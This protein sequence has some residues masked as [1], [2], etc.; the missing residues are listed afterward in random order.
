MQICPNC[1]EQNPDR[2]RLCGIC[3]TQFASEQVVEEVRKTVTVVFSD[4]KG[5]TDLGERLDTERLREVLNVYFNEMRSVLERHGGTVEKYIGDAIMAV[6]GLPKVHEDDAIRAVRAAFEMKRTLEQVNDR[7]EAGWGV[8][9]QNRTG[10]NTG[11][12]VAGDVSTGQRLV[13]GDTVNTAARLEQAAPAMEILIGEPTYRLVRDAVQVEPVEPLELKGK[14][15]PVPAYLLAGVLEKA[16]GIARRLDAPMVGRDKEFRTLVEALERAETERTA[17]LVT[18][19]GPAGVGKSRLLREFLHAT[20]GRANALRGRCLSYGDG[21]TFWP[22]A[23][24]IREAAGITDADPLDDARAKLGL[25]AGHEGHDAAERVAA[26]IGL[27][28]ATFPIQETFWG[29]R[30]LVEVLTR[31]RPTI[32]VIDDIHWA[33]DTFLELLQYLAGHVEAPLL[34]LCSSRPELLEDHADWI[35]ERDDARTILL[36]ALTE[37]ESE[38]VI[39]NLLGSAIGG[40]LRTAII[41]A[42]QGNPL[43]VE[44]MLSMLMEEGVV[45]QDGAGRWTLLGDVKAQTIPPSISALIT[46]RLDRLRSSERTVIERAAVIG[47]RFVRDAVEHLVATPVRPQVD[48]SLDALA[49]KEL[50]RRDGTDLVRHDAY[51]FLHIL[52]RDAAYHGLLKRTRAELHERFVDWLES[53]QSDR[54]TEYDEIRGYHLEQAYL[55][56]LQL[57][58][59]DEVT[60]RIGI[61]GAGYLSSS[62][63]RA[64]ARGDMPAAATLLR[65]AA[66]LLPPADVERAHLLLEAGEALIEV[67]EFATADD[68]LSAAQESGADI[69]D[70]AICE[71]AGLVRLQLRYSTQ[72]AEERAIVDEVQRAMAVLEREDAHDGLSRAWRLLTIVHWTA[73]RYAAAEDATLQMI[74]H[75]RV[76]GD[77]ITGRRYLG[78]LAISELYGPTPASEAIKRCEELLFEA[79]GDRKAEALISCALA[80]LEAMEGEFE[81]AR[82]LFARSRASFEELGWNLDA[83]L[84]SIDSGP[85]ELLAGDPRAAEAELRRDFDALKAMGEANYIS[86][87]AGL[88]ADAVY[89]QD[90]IDESEALTTF[91][92]EVAADDDV[93]SQVLWRCVRAKILARRGRFDDGV[94]L[95]KEAVAMI[96]ASDCLD[97]QGI[98]AMDLADVLRSAGRTDEANAA[99][100]Q[101][102]DAFERKGNL[103]SASRARGFL[104]S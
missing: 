13:T 73:C 6:F 104:R 42:A 77:G 27:S 17:Q 90:R 7:L 8:R 97:Y 64:L 11:E 23:E 60:A 80:H 57:G 14:S 78:S 72:G 79:Q 15:Q 10:V 43:Y 103:V 41:Q 32:V 53:T 20:A 48:D 65:R 58:P 37:D 54:I 83:A 16:D 71:T 55:I 9:L 95:A 25:F 24:V 19:F 70:V 38:Q 94:S 5:S 28:E 100:R 69:G 87:T 30:R 50:V 61:R 52:I 12:I 36:E 1:G 62:G 81:A 44:Q 67:G 98:A 88:L 47:Y 33:E 99:A 45:D 91:C 46:A 102:L 82:E 85:A 66:G 22:L 2:F 18:V 35:Q 26:A 92:Q 93:T 31:E 74:E 75:A 4:L 101:A 89:Q 59:L 34:L 56:K 29:A 39:S 51:R 86:T 96:A 84:T 68:V 21:I 76:A 40:K 63:R 3:G 49:R